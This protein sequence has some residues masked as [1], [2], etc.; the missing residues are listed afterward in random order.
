MRKLQ[1]WNRDV[2][3]CIAVVAMMLNHISAVFLPKG[4]FLGELFLD[5]GYFTAPV[6]IYFL[7]EGYFYTHSRK[8]YALRLLAFGFLSQV[9]FYMALSPDGKFPGMLNMMFSLF[10]CFLIVEV[11]MQIHHGLLKFACYLLLILIL[12]FCDWPTMSFVYTFLFID[13]YG[14]RERLKKA[15]VIATIAFMIPMYMTNS[16]LFDTGKALLLTGGSALGVLVAGVVLVYLYNGEKATRGTT[17]S[18]WFFYL[19]YPVH[20][21]VIGWI[22]MM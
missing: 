14:S 3:K 21:L 16:M 15:F 22:R 4:T 18:K 11:T 19:F 8:K 1:V 13:A 6:M 5:V 9:P 20:L 2:I 12:S 10:F 17:C 7:V